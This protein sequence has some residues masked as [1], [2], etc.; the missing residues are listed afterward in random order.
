MKTVKIELTED[1]HA[2]LKALAALYKTTLPLIVKTLAMTSGKDWLQ[3]K[4]QVLSQ[5]A[6]G[7]LEI[8]SQLL[9]KE[10]VK[11]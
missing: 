5:Q 3:N 2:I 10:G 6:D 9:E 8:L 11:C 4:L 7:Q 1:E